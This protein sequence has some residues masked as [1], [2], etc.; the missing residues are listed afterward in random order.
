MMTSTTSPAFTPGTPPSATAATSPV[1]LGVA[2]EVAATKEQWKSL[3]VGGLYF[4]REYD[5]DTGY[6]VYSMSSLW[7]INLR[8]L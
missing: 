4:N 8:K 3:P 2:V 5:F 1:L 6:I 7:S